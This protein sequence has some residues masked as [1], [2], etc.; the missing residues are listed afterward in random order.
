M[1]N[2][3]DRTAELAMMGESASVASKQSSGQFRI[4][5]SVR[6]DMPTLNQESSY[7]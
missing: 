6:A 5:R 3:D 4:I 7:E 1:R 2:L